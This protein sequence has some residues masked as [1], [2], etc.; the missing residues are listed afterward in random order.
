MLAPA[1]G[2]VAAPDERDVGRAA[3]AHGKAVQVAAVL[4]RQ[5]RDEARMP[6]RRKTVRGA[7]PRQAGEQRVDEDGVA[8]GVERDVV[9]VDVAGDVAHLRDVEAVEAVVRLPGLQHVLEAPELIER[10]HPQRLAISAEPHAPL[11]RALEDGKAPVGLEAEEEE[12]ARLIGGERQA[13]AAARRA[14]PRNAGTKRSTSAGCVPDGAGF[15]SCPPI[16]PPWRPLRSASS[17]L[18]HWTLVAS[19]PERPNGHNPC[20]RGAE[21]QWDSAHRSKVLCGVAHC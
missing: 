21:N 20:R 4:G 7:R 6:D 19:L 9:H 14:M 11:E 12:L 8:G 16:G 15:P 3:V 10:A 18:P 2:H 17:L 1:V 5:P 13:R